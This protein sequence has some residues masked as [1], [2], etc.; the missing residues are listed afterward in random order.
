VYKNFSPQALGVLG[1]QSEMIEYAL[2]YGFRGL[3]VDMH[4][5]VTR[6]Q[7]KDL[8]YAARYLKAA[9]ILR[10]GFEAPVQ[11]GADEA[12]FNAAFAK[13]A[14]MLQIAGQLDVKRAYVELPNSSDTHSYRELFDVCR[15]R[16]SKMAEVAGNSG[17]K[18]GVGFRAGADEKLKAY[19]FIR[20]VEG[21][22]ALMR[23]VKSPHLGYMLDSWNWF[24]GGGGKD[25][26]TEITG[27]DV[28]CVRLAD[29]AGSE[30]PATMRYFDRDLPSMKGGIDHVKF[31]QHLKAAGYAGPVSVFPHAAALRGRTREVI[32]RAAQDAI[33]R[34]L[35]STGVVV[36]PKPMDMVHDRQ[37]AELEIPPA[38]A[39]QA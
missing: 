5:I 16:L 26:L 3:D 29:A 11:L 18:I 28:V 13:L 2:T 20:D 14:N 38:I 22:M 9:D 34:I 12:G 25:Q 23:A 1:R 17:V 32:V 27:D 24:V 8:D 10:T 4:D 21:Y 36:P 7:R 37:D 31:L 30:D 35:E 19:P 15:D 33:D 39:N 6:T